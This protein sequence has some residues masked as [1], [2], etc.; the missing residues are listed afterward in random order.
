MNPH[1]PLAGRRGR[2]F[3]VEDHPLVRQALISLLNQQPDLVSCGEASSLAETI[4]AVRTSKP[5]LVL[6]DMR[7]TD[8]DSLALIRPLLVEFPMLRILVLSQHDETLHAEPALRAGAHGYIMKECASQDVLGA[9]RTVLLGEIYVSRKMAIRLANRYPG[10]KVMAAPAGYEHLTD[11]EWQVLQLMGCEMGTR[12]I[13]LVLK[14]SVKT[15][16]TY[17][18]RLKIKLGLS[19][20]EKLIGYAEQ[21]VQGKCIL[22]PP[23]IGQSYP[24]SSRRA[25][26]SQPR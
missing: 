10:I 22:P 1:D 8:G 18:E 2:I 21:M 17:R 15:V 13:A 12:E 23:A 6:L 11:R 7:L 25:G 16:E 24:A 9:I 19:D 3:V 26:A 5:D 14:L 4:P 20:A